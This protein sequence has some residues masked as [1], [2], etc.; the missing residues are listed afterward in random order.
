MKNTLKRLAC[1]AVVLALCLS[2]VWVP[3]GAVDAETGENPTKDFVL[4]LD[5]TDTMTT[6]D[7][8]KLCQQAY[9]QFID[10]VPVENARVSVIAYGPGGSTYKMDFSKYSDAGN[11]GNLLQFVHVL[12]PLQ[13]TS[14]IENMKKLKNAIDGLR[15]DGLNTPVATA[16]RVAI[17]VLEKGGA[18]DGNACMIL[19]T[20]CD[21]Q[22]QHAN[23]RTEQAAID[24]AIS[25]MKSHNWKI[26]PIQMNFN[27]AFSDNDENTTLTM[28][29]MAKE[30]GVDINKYYVN[31]KDFSQGA[32]DINKAIARIITYMFVGDVID[33][34]EIQ[35][36][37]CDTEK[38]IPIMTSEFN[39]TLIGVGIEKAILT[40]PD[41]TEKVLDHNYASEGGDLI[42]NWEGEYSSFNNK[43]IKLFAPPSGTYH[44][45]IEGDTAGNAAALF[46]YGVTNPV[47]NMTATYKDSVI[48]G[49]DPEAKLADYRKTDT[50]T[51]SA[52]FDYH[53]HAL[54]EEVYNGGAVTA[55]LKITNAD[56]TTT[57]VPMEGAKDCYKL[58]LPVQGNDVG[59]SFTGQVMVEYEGGTIWSEECF[60][61]KTTNKPCTL[62][63]EVIPDQKGNLNGSFEQIDLAAYVEN[64]DGDKLDYSIE[65][66]SDRN[67]KFDYS[68]DNDYLTILCGTVPGEYQMQIGIKDAE[69]SEY[70]Y[71]EPFTLTVINRP[72]EVEKI[73]EVEIWVDDWIFGLLD[74]DE[75][76][77]SC[78]VDLADYYSDP[79]GMPLTI[80]QVSLQ[81]DE[82]AVEMSLNGTSVTLKALD[83]GE[84]T[85]TFAVDDGVQDTIHGSLS[86]RALSA[87]QIF[88]EHNWLW[89]VIAIAVIALTILVL[90]IRNSNKRA[91]GTWDIELRYHNQTAK[92]DGLDIGTG[93]T[94]TKKKT[95]ALMDMLADILSY[96]DTDKGVGKVISENYQT[97]LSENGGK[98]IEIRGI[99]GKRG[100]EICKIPSNDDVTIEYNYAAVDKKKKKV[101]VTGGEVSFEFVYHGDTKTETLN[102]TFTSI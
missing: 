55:K 45:H 91:R 63:G 20:D 59:P 84:G 85:L 70:L 90:L 22:T 41:G 52:R 66:I 60:R 21:V 44:L 53:G 4:V 80:S 64:P 24:E 19:I 40:Y 100:F 1:L 34:E 86:V 72:I 36:L 95:F 42:V 50:V 32:L 76:L 57:T 30:T 6:N 9:Y 75:S 43:V 94:C 83:K 26:F 73:P 78:T 65:C 98:Q 102:V 35:E 79:D 68:I 28:Q 14:S 3:V 25:V 37:P 48:S 93:L 62:T 7:P 49:A 81:Q 16:M 61:I 15:M 99:L 87:G 31:M 10:Q 2:A 29:R 13:E 27:G 71:L 77:L 51:V 33:E 11:A 46:T 38:Y 74:K 18:T 89:I 58:V 39:I 17:D 96:V 92:V 88:W 97:I 101:K 54:P 67:V 12:E 47:L 23:F 8:Y 82:E 56:G 69:M 5:Y